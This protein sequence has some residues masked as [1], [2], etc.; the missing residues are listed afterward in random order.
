MGVCFDCHNGWGGVGEEDSA[1]LYRAKAWD[2][3]YPRIPRIVLHEIWTAPPP[4]GYT[5]RSQALER[6]VTDQSK[7]RF[8]C[9]PFLLIYRVPDTEVEIP[10]LTH[11]HFLLLSFPGCRDEKEAGCEACPGA[12]VLTEAWSLRRPGQA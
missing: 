9:V 1:R 11:E 5:L 12:H 2:A 4:W 10:M 7:A 6:T 3:K 8:N